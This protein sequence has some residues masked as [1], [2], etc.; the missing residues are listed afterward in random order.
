MCFIFHKQRKI[1]V[2]FLS[3]NIVLTL[4]VVKENIF[5]SK[6]ISDSQTRAEKTAENPNCNCDVIK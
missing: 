4:L 5:M 2:T 1:S 6:M 3:L